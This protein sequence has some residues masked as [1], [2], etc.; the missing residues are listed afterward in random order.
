MLIHFVRVGDD[1]YIVP[2]VLA[3]IER[4]DVGISPYESY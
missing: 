1:A 4:A 2:Q 3:G